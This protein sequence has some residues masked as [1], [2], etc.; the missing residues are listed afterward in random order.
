MTLDQLR[1]LVAGS[2]ANDWHRIVKAG[3]TYRDRF[4]A[5]SGP[6][7]SS[8]LEHDTHDEVGWVPR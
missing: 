4:G 2:T 6:T 7:G 8:G 1:T 3:P 5:W